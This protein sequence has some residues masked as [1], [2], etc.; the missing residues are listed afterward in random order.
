MILTSLISNTRSAWHERGNSPKPVI[1]QIIL[2]T[3]I[4]VAIYLA[5]AVI[6]HPHGPEIS[7]DFQSEQGIVTVLS[8][9]LLASGGAWAFAA[10][11]LAPWPEK[12]YRLFWLILGIG[13]GFLALDELIGFHEKAGKALY[14]KTS[15]SVLV[16]ETPLRNLNDLVVISYGLIALPMAII[17]LPGLLRVPRVLELLCVAFACYAVHTLIDSVSEPPTNLTI[18]M[19]ETAKVLSSCFIALAMLAGLLGTT[20]QACELPP[21]KT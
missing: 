4:V 10:F 12:R 9:V 15:L 13:I 1:G 19:E 20:A 11:T 16:D 7:S 6:F 2:L 14:E 18:I 3:L 5:I 21:R 8:A 17:F